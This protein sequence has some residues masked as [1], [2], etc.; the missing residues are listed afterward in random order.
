M[1]LPASTL[2]SAAKGLRVLATLILNWPIVLAL[3]CVIS[4]ISLH[5]ELPYELSNAPCRYVGTRGIIDTGRVKCP[6][7]ALIDTRTN[8][9]ARFDSLLPISPEEKTSW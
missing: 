2:T 1:S 7:I 5:V 4:P 8:D 3:V 9:F 6:I